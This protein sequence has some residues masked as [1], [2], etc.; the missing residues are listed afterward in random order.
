MPRES[1]LL[2]LQQNAVPFYRFRI[3]VDRPPPVV[4]ERLRSIGR[5]KPTFRESL[6]NMWPS[7]DLAT[8]PFIG[9]VDVESFKIRRDIRYR[10][11]FLPMIWGRIM[12]NGFGT[13]VSGIM[14]L[15]PL[16]ALFMI[17]WLGMARFGAVSAASMSSMVPSGVFLF[18]VTLMVGAFFPE[19]MKAKTLIS[20]AVTKVTAT[21]RQHISTDSGR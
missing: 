6:R 1:R 12:P 8:T 7:G 3:D 18:G 19:A 10:N 16:V 11:S 13:Q 9:S 20:D 17:F 2:E 4:A 15:H 21:T 5:N 14:F